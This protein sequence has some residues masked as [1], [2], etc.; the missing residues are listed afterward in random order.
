MK[1][2]VNMLKEINLPYAYDH[3]GEGNAPNPPFICYLYTGSDNFSADGRVYLKK[4]QVNIELYT[5]KK[6]VT[7]EQTVEDV[8]DSY[9]IFYN[10]SEVYIESEKLYEV[11][12]QFT[13]EVDYEK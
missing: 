1:K 12:Y 4:N 13:L 9:G 5:D 7:L 8:L 3:F 10:K 6:A 2:V 11:L